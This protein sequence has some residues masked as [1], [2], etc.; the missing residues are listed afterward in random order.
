MLTSWQTTNIAKQRPHP[1]INH[2][3]IAAHRNIKKALKA[4]PAVEPTNSTNRKHKIHMS[5]IRIKSPKR[6]IR[7]YYPP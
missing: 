7:V 6:K 5:P 1:L 4:I 3:K 2:L